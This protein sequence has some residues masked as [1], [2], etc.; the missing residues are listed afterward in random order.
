MD[1]VG[2]RGFAFF[3][4]GL[5]LRSEIRLR[6]DMWSE[7]RPNQHFSEPLFKRRQLLASVQK[8]D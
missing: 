1:G 2:L 5:K 8:R 6:G 3:E 4:E 7:S